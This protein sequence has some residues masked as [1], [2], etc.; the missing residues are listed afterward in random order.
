MDADAQT[1]DLMDV[2]AD[3][4][5]I[6]VSGSS[7]SSY[8][9]AETALAVTVADVAVAMTACGSSSC[10]SSVVASATLEAAADVDATTTATK[11][12]F[13]QKGDRDFNPC[14]LLTIM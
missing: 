7:Y 8:A 13:P 4:E 5:T 9:V 10:C 6:L 3:L 1:K 11:I 2:D 12:I 14:R